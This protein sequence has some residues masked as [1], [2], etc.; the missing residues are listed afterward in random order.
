MEEQISTKEIEQLEEINQDITKLE[1]KLE[2]LPG[3]E[4]LDM[5]K[6]NRK[7]RRRLERNIKHQEKEKQTKAI[8]QGNTTVTRR[9][10][11][12]LFQSMQKLRDRMYYIDVLVASIEKLLVEKNILSGD[13]LQAKVKEE[14]ERALAFQGIQNSQKDYE[15]RIK[16]CIDLN[17]DPN[18]SII[19]QQIYEDADMSLDEK[20]KLAETYK[21]DILLKIFK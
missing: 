1:Q 3:A 16:K 5:S 17:I 10:F 13:E 4:A 8:Q 21:L 2:E 18:I 11:V 6:Y 7:Q 19:P 12:G 15:E 20:K 14:A 9:E